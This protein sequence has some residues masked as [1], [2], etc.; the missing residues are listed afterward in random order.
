MK[1][2]AGGMLHHE[3]TIFCEGV[4]GVRAGFAAPYLAKS[5]IQQWKKNRRFKGILHERISDGSYAKLQSLLMIYSDL[6][7]LQCLH[8]KFS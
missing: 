7:S 4:S 6:F 5:Y 3:K 8:D 1:E 2:P